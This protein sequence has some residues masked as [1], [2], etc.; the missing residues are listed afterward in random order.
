MNNEKEFDPDQLLA[1]TG[2]SYL[3]PALTISIIA[4]I[5]LIGLTSFGLYADWGEYGVKCDE[6][7]FHTPS[8]VNLH[9]TQAQKAAEEAARKAKLEKEA[10]E[11]A[12]KDAAAAEAAEKKASGA[13]AG[14]AKE[15]AA[16]AKEPAAANGQVK[17]PEVEPMAPAQVGE[18]DLD[19]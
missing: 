1:S 9:R 8:I 11:R 12:K 10:D 3:T 6:H 16:A 7:S 2:A 13:S 4:H 5:V 14:Q 18:F 15:P 19:I 17:P